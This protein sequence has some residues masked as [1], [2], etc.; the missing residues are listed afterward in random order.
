MLSALTARQCGTA[1][2]RDLEKKRR[3]DHGRMAV[4]IVKETIGA[5]KGMS[6]KIQRTMQGIEEM[7]REGRVVSEITT[8]TSRGDK[9][10]DRENEKS[11]RESEVD[12]EIARRDTKMND[13][14][15]EVGTS[16]GVE[17]TVGIV[18]EIMGEP[19]ARINTDHEVFFSFL[20][21]VLEY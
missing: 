21:A 8:K 20:L 19:E 9:G 6:R 10:L 14:E 12:Q 13:V 16:K 3:G 11:E 17:M 7:L 2:L 5:I 1:T 4:P 15:I 18:E